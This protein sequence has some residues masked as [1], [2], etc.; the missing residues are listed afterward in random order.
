MAGRGSNSKAARGRSPDQAPQPADRPA[1]ESLEHAPRAAADDDP[2]SGTSTLSDVM[3][4]GT[5]R[6]LET[7]TSALA[8]HTTDRLDPLRKCTPK[9]EGAFVAVNHKKEL[10]GKWGP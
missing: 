8:Q 4:R 5:H 6:T 2:P 7:F 9:S 3:K 1:A 10:K